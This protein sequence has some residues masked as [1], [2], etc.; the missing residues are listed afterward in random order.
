MLK[1]L[2]P[3]SITKLRGFLGL[4]RY[5]RKFVEHYQSVCKTLTKLLQG[6]RVWHQDE[7]T[8]KTFETLKLAMTQTPALALPKFDISFVIETHAYDEC[9]G[10]MLMQMD[11][12]IAFLNKE[13]GVKIDNYPFMKRSFL[14]LFQQRIGGVHICKYLSLSLRRIIR[15]CLFQGSNSCYM[16]SDE[17][18]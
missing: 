7:D 13:L 3:S 16:I 18:Q 1:W 11:R 10:T 5:Y 15:L 4:T 9:I 12:H 2:T 8:Q 6:K 17:S 14:P